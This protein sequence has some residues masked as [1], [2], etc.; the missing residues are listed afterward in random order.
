LVWPRR[1]EA[2]SGSSLECST[3]STVF[4]TQLRTTSC[5]FWLSLSPSPLDDEGDGLLEPSMS[6]SPYT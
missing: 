2:G 6:R 1:I 4:C 5:S 3:S